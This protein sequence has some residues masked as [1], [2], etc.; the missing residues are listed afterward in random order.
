MTSQE[1]GNKEEDYR[2]SNIDFKEE[3]QYKYKIECKSCG[4]SFY[5]QRIN[6]NFA[7]KYR[8]GKCGGSFN[9]IGIDKIPRKMYN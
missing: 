6:K 4:Y 3:R 5:R 2:K 7:K 9:I 1:Y 8:C